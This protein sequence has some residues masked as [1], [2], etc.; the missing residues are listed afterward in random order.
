M[1][2]FCKLAGARTE[3]KDLGDGVVGNEYFRASINYELPTELRIFWEVEDNKIKFNVQ[4]A[5]VS[6]FGPHSVCFSKP[7]EISS[8]SDAEIK[9]LIKLFCTRFSILFQE[10]PFHFMSE[11]QINALLHKLNHEVSNIGDLKDLDFSAVSLNNK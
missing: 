5:L 3:K 6:M 4:T 1:K 7:I 11:E 2:N 10:S 9:E 8:K